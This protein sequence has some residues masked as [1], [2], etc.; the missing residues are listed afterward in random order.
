MTHSIWS[1]EK[2]VLEEECL[3][4][5]ANRIYEE[6]Y[7]Y[8]LFEINKIDNGDGWYYAISEQ[9]GDEWGDY[10]DLKAE[11]YFTMKQYQP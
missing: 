11:L 5:I 9:G 1:K 6:K 3:L 4:I 7:E 10:D 8:A 2:P